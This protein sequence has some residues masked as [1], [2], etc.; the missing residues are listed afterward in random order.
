MYMSGDG[1]V[2]DEYSAK[3]AIIDGKRNLCAFVLRPLLIM[4]FM[5]HCA[6]DNARG[7][8]RQITCG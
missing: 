7:F 2:D 4:Y 1:D 8:I 3:A 6:E 5:A